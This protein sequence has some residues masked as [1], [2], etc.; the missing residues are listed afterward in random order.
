MKIQVLVSTMSNNNTVELVKK[1]NINA[2][3]V[4]FLSDE[5]KEKYRK[6]INFKTNE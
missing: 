4:A 5:L 3:N 6:I 1:M 2:I